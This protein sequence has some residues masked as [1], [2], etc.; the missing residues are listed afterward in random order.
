MFTSWMMKPGRT[1]LIAVEKVDASTI[2]SPVTVQFTLTPECTTY[3]P[4]GV[5]C[6]PS[7]CDGIDCGT[8]SGND[9]CVDGVC[10]PCIADCKQQTCGGPDGCGGK[11]VCLSENLSKPFPSIMLAHYRNPG[12]CDTLSPKCY[13]NKGSINLQGCPNGQFCSSEC[14]CLP[15]STKLPDLAIMDFTPYLDTL[16]VDSNNSCAYQE[17]CLRGTGARLVIKF[18]TKVYNQGRV[19]LELPSPPQ[20][21]PD[22]FEFARCH[23]HWHSKDFLSFELLDLNDR[24]VTRGEKRSFCLMDSEQ[25]LKRPD[26]PCSGYFGC[27]R[28]GLSVGWT[29]IYDDS[30]DCQF[31]DVTGVPPGTYVVRQCVNPKRKYDEASYENNCATARINIPPTSS[32]TTH[33]PTPPTNSPLPPCATGCPRSW[34]GDQV[35]D[36]VAYHANHVNVH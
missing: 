7:G 32:P 1:Y 35:R 16:N 15:L 5:Q 6:G 2:S 18:D 36:S 17:G 27:D 12:D 14:R 21:R 13:F 8:C 26:A 29:D 34:I 31:I 10:L 3:C 19:A 4:V 25:I 20:S 33:T 28:Q 9:I 22:L 24:L 23:G 11:C 30:L